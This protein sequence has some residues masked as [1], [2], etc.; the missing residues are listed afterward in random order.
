MERERER[1]RE[2]MVL[3]VGTREGRLTRELREMQLFHRRKRERRSSGGRER[4]RGC[5][6]ADEKVSRVV[7]VVQ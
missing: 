3:P 7:V 4:E 5:W 2:R 1:E 6:T